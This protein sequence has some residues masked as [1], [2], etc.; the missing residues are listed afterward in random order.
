MCLVLG[1]I[2]SMEEK[3]VL[4]WKMI[5]HRSIISR[6]REANTDTDTDWC[7]WFSS[8]INFHVLFPFRENDSWWEKYDSVPNWY[9][10]K[11]VRKVLGK[12][13]FCFLVHP[14]CLSFYCIIHALLNYLSIAFIKRMSSCLRECQDISLGVKVICYFIVHH[15]LPPLPLPWSRTRHY[16]D[17]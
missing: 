8:L 14:T 10:W 12:S 15:L 13:Y 2:S 9:K 7:P 3:K 11:V 6:V 17:V 16:P 5:F 1:R 4:K